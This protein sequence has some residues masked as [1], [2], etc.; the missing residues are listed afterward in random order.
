MIIKHNILSI[1][2]TMNLSHIYINFNFALLGMITA[3][4]L[5]SKEALVPKSSTI[6]ESGSFG[7]ASSGP[8]FHIETKDSDSE[9]VLIPKSSINSNSASNANAFGI[10]AAGDVSHGRHRTKTKA[11]ALDSEEVPTPKNNVILASITFSIDGSNVLSLLEVK[12]LDKGPSY[13]QE[14]R[15]FCVQHFHRMAV[16]YPFLKPRPWTSWRNSPLPRVA[17]FLHPTLSELMTVI[18]PISK[19][20]PCRKI[21]SSRVAPSPHQEG[22]AMFLVT[23][24]LVKHHWCL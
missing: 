6:S 1:I 20:R 13:N 7:I 10:A 24:F 12:A 22:L 2:I 4:A 17:P 19:S 8:I 5:D 23:S 9:E 11:K 16:T 3:N 14:Q 21:L 15:H 18:S